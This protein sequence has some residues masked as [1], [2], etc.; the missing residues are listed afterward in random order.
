MINLKGKLQNP[1]DFFKMPD[2]F[3]IFFIWLAHKYHMVFS[4]EELVNSTVIID[5]SNMLKPYMEGL[6]LSVLHV[7]P[8][9]HPTENGVIAGKF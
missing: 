1:F 2:F 8:E 7:P 4:L 6:I 5:H 9:K 3:W